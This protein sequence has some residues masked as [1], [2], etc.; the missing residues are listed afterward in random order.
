MVLGHGFVGRFVAALSK[1]ILI[2]RE[3]FLVQYR[4]HVIL[5]CGQQCHQ[6]KPGDDQSS[7]W[8][9]QSTTEYVPNVA[10]RFDYGQ[11][12]GSGTAGCSLFYSN[13][14]DSKLS[15]INGLTTFRV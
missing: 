6:P 1:R 14:F 5:A 9:L 10:L 7:L 4:V 12:P 15:D 8:C 13:R 11:A 2:L 3:P